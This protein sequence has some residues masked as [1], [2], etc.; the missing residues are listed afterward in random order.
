MEVIEVV[1]QAMER[2]DTPEYSV[3]RA[4]LNSSPMQSA[5]GLRAKGSRPCISYRGIDVAQAHIESLHDK[6]REELLNPELF[7]SLREARVI[8]KQ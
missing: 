8:P 4:A 7:G 2:S 6:L 1:R 5:T 3:A